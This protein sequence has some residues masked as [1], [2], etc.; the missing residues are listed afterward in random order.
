MAPH[1]PPESPVSEATL[2]AR[3]GWTEE[4]TTRTSSPPVFLT[5]AFDIESLEQLDAVTSGREKGYI[6]TRDGNPN[7]EA[8]ASDVA[9]LEGAEAGVVTASGMGALTAVLMATVQSG[10]H[11]L[12]ARVLYGR[13]GQLLNHLVASFGLKVTYFDVAD[14]ASVGQLVTPQ[15]KLC[16][17][18]SISNPLLE[19]ADLPGIVAAL[20][21]VPLLV[22]S[23]FGTPSL[24]RPISLG[25]TLVWHSVSKY[26]NGHGDVMAGVVVGPYGLIRKIRAMSSLYGVNANPFES[27][28]ASRGLRTLP[29]RM[30][31]VSQ[32]ALTVARFLKSQPQV[33]RVFYPGLEDHPDHALALRLLPRGCGGMLSFDLSGGR[34]AVDSLFRALAHVIPFSP[35]L[36][37]ART[38][39]SYP[40]G[41]SHKF[42]TA[43]ERAEYGIGDGLVRLSIGLEDPADLQSDLMRGLGAIDGHSRAG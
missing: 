29:L 3:G 12:A 16:I 30:E 41:T 21:G 35:T 10:D 14:V 27:W 1:N 43:A 39:V 15:T 25:A 17:V 9:R 28:L 38:T 13:T 23:T 7:H 19:V 4:F 34:A 6:Y 37:D 22:D 24:I 42:M 5:T 36:A 31:R 18:E 2:A 33:T 20:G 40:A 8:F 11:V 26:L 32:T